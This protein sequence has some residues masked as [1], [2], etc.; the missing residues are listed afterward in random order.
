MKKNSKMMQV[1]A[2]ILLI[3]MIAISISSGTFA[4]YTSSLNGEDT[5]TVAKWDV[6]LG[7]NDNTIDLFKNVYD[8]NGVTNK[9]DLSLE[10][11]KADADVT[12]EKKVAPG[13]WGKTT[14]KVTNASDVTAEAEITITG[15][16]NG[17]SQL[18]FSTNGKDWTTSN[19]ISQLKYSKIKVP[20]NASK[21]NSIDLYWKWDF[22]DATT[23][24]KNDAIDNELGKAG[25]ATCKVEL[26]AVVTQVD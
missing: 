18:Q 19:D 25:T 24:G 17:I 23:P 10:E 22:D 16:E 26:K 11:G 4:K 9:N 21:G 12:G 14:I 2:V 13:T 1:T 5:A 3:T 7:I 6:S 8:L 15:I 20:K